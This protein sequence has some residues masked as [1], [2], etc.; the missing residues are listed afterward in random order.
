[1]QPFR[2]LLQQIQ[3]KP[4]L[5][6]DLTLNSTRSLPTIMFQLLLQAH[7]LYLTHSLMVMLT[8]QINISSISAQFALITEGLISFGPSQFGTIGVNENIEV[9]SN[10][11][12]GVT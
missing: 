4:T 9:G 8:F 7:R 3:L 11:R 6:T 12:I 1:M 5:S 10:L 2:E